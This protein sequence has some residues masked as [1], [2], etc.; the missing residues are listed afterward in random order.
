LIFQTLTIIWIWCQ[1]KIPTRFVI[2]ANMTA[3]M[4]LDESLR[5]AR[6]RKAFSRPLTG[7][8]V[9]RHKLADRERGAKSTFDLSCRIEESNVD[10]TPIFLLREWLFSAVP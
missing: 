10:L 6:D 3:Q 1:F 9:T 7:F 2:M 8:Q 5:Y 4:A